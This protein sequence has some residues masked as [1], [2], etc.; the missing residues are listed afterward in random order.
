MNGIQALIQLVL[1]KV[2]AKKVGTEIEKTFKESGDK[3]GKEFSDSVMSRARTMLAGDKKIKDAGIELAKTLRAAFDR[4]LADIRVARSQNLISDREAA[5]QGVEA[6]KHHKA[7]FLRALDAPDLSSGAVAKLTGGVRAAEREGKA[8]AQGVGGSIKKWAAG[9]AAS[10]ATLFAVQKIYSFVSDSVSAFMESNRASEAMRESARQAAAAW[11]DFRASVGEAVVTMLGGEAGVD[12]L[13]DKLRDL[14]GWVD[15]NRETWRTWGDALGSIARAVADQFR[16]AKNDIDALV[17]GARRGGAWL[18]DRMGEGVPNVVRGSGAGGTWS[19]P[20]ATGKR[21]RLNQSVL[22][23]IRATTDLNALLERQI[24]VRRALN[25]ERA[26]ANPIK[27]RVEA[28][29][30]ELT[31]VGTRLE[32]VRAG[33]KDARSAE[34]A[35]RKAQREME[36]AARKAEREAKKAAKDEEEEQRRRWEREASFDNEVSGRGMDR[37]ALPKISTRPMAMQIVTSYE[38]HQAAIR[39]T[40]EVWRDAHRDMEDTTKNVAA[41]IVDSFGSA[42]EMMVTGAGTIGDAF[43]G[44]GAGIAADILGGIKQMALGK[45]AENIAWAFEKFAHGN[46]PQGVGFLAAAAKWTAAGGLAAGIGGAMGGIGR[47]GSGRRDLWPGDSGQHA[48]A[49]YH[50]HIS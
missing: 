2:S 17:E 4:E 3:A 49:E 34:T 14:S 35:A 6:A 10:I 5:R 7:A 33:A 19:A 38:K 50:V 18:R 44:I 25:D 32:E 26:K 48:A 31:E 43:V 1:D 47:G 30:L 11:E 8:Y 20:G 45:A 22:N 16:R 42:I 40:A 15:D 24:K 12:S 13:A 41:G 39:E 9:V 21:T 27:H 36:A 37:M 28:L 23:E 46:V 29:S